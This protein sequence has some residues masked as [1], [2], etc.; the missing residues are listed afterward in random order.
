[1]CVVCV[2]SVCVS[3]GVDVCECTCGFSVGVDVCGMCGF[4]EKGRICECVYI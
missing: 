4:I 1:M 2:G 3:V